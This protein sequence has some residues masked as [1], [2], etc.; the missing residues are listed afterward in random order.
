MLSMAGVCA[1]A[2][3]DSPKMPSISWLQLVTER[4]INQYD[5]HIIKCI[6]T[7]SY[8]VKNNF[9]VLLKQVQS[10]SISGCTGL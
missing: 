7:H 8:T 3:Q 2:G 5:G 10:G 1:P 9:V 4:I 6:Y